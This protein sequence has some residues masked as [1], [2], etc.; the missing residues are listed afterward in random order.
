[1][2]YAQ[3]DN[4]QSFDEPDPIVKRGEALYHPLRAQLEG[5]NRGQYIM[6]N[7]QTGDYVIAKT[8]SDTH[9]KF[10]DAFGFDTPGWC[11]RIGASI[12]VSV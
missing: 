9:S 6:I 4:D 12:F 7:T 3:P 8:L 11:T 1:M 5:T 2:T 10:I